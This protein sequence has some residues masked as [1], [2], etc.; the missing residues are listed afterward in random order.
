MTRYRQVSEPTEAEGIRV[1]WRYVT[2][3]PSLKVSPILQIRFPPYEQVYRTDSASTIN[4]SQVHV[5]APVYLI[6]AIN[7]F[8]QLVR[9]ARY[10][11][12]QSQPQYIAA[13]R[14]I[15]KNYLERHKFPIDTP[16]IQM[17]IFNLKCCKFYFLCITF[18]TK[19]IHKPEIIFSSL[20]VRQ[21]LTERIKVT[22]MHCTA[23]I[24]RK[25]ISFLSFFLLSRA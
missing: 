8:V 7:H 14:P 1:D 3:F 9:H 11:R 18:V 13:F 16:A 24:G 17:C 2:V 15:H 20:S 6:L 23:A 19:T 22:I 21:T 12:Y 10:P 25:F 5:L 4:L